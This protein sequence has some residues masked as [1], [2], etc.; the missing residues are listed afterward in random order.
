MQLGLPTGCVQYGGVLDNIRCLVMSAP[1]AA[2]NKGSDFPHLWKCSLH[3]RFLLIK[4][5][6]MMLESGL[7]RSLEW[8]KFDG[9]RNACEWQ[10]QM[11][12]HVAWCVR[13][14]M[15]WRPSMPS[16]VPGLGT[17]L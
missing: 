11:Q 1:I 5:C 16:W 7:R 9:W 6:C 2:S 3:D 12:R 14:L 8:R 13:L 15:N 17:H 4:L 10:T